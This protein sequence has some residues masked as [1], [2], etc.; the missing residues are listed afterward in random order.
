MMNM[1][2]DGNSWLLRCT[3][4]NSQKRIVSGLFDVVAANDDFL[5]VA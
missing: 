1:K 3:G 5:E 2:I 4:K